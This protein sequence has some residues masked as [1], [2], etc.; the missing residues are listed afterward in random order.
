MVQSKFAH[1]DAL[2][3]I[4]FPDPTNTYSIL[5]V[6]E[7]SFRK[8]TGQ[9]WGETWNST[10]DRIECDPSEHAFEYSIDWSTYDPNA[11]NGGSSA[12]AGFPLGGLMALSAALSA[13]LF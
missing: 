9:Y 1:D 2:I 10:D 12:A 13:F 11:G 5:C 7:C 3:A 6:Y 8:I 4:F